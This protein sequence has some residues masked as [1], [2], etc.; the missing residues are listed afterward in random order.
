[1]FELSPSKVME[2]LSQKQNTNRRASSVTQV[3]ESFP[4]K[5]EALG[6]ISKTAK[7]KTNNK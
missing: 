5:L 7:Q 2:T 1:M 6:L 4:R 3:V